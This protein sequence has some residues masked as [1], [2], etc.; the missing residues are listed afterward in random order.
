MRWEGEKAVRGNGVREGGG[1]AARVAVLLSW[2]L[3]HGGWGC[4]LVRPTWETGLGVPQN[5]KNRTAM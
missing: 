2:A 4:R 5:V 1:G 3:V